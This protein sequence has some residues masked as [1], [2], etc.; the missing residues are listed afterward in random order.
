M[1]NPNRPM[2]A[3]QKRGTDPD[4]K[5][6]PRLAPIGSASAKSVFE[7]KPSTWTAGM[8]MKV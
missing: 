5:L 1:Y 3:A 7:G 2:D 8:T 6:V 4:L